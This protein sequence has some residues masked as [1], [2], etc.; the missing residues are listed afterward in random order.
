MT[1]PD[2]VYIDYSYDAAHRLTGMTDSAG[3]SIVYTLDAMGNRIN[4]QVKDPSG[5]LVKQ[6]TRVIDALNRI[7]QI[8]G[9]GSL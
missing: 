9:S 4:E 6:T 7:Q 3:S 1:L 2:G 5:Q 8:T